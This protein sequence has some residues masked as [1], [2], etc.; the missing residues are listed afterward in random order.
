MS[1]GVSQR[2]WIARQ[3]RV[4][5]RI[6]L[7]SCKVGVNEYHGFAVGEFPAR[8]AEVR[9][10]DVILSDSYDGK[11][12]ESRNR[13]AMDHLPTSGSRRKCYHRG[14]GAAGKYRGRSDNVI[15]L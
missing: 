2:P 9:K 10:G 11:Q 3:Y 7:E 5:R 1:E 14:G 8:S 13:D 12:K 15:E 6:G 4:V